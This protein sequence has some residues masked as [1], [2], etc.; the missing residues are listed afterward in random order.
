LVILLA[1]AGAFLLHETRGTTLWFDEWSWAFERRGD[2][3]ASL[4]E[5]HNEHLSLV[6][7]AIYKVLFATAG[8]ENHLP[9]RALVIA[10]HLACTA[11]LFAYVRQRAGNLLGLLAA[12]L[13]LF[14]GPGW[15]NILWPFQVGWLLS[16]AAGIGSLLLLDRRDRVGRVAA[17][18]LLGL[19]L[20]SSGIGL[21]VAAGAL[22]ELLWSRER[23]LV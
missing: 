1:C 8:L 12:A 17:C 11:L 6:P 15:H 20:I 18:G 19:S 14:L 10:G 16:L 5:P 4:L 7:V 9:Y 13:L 23:K 3:L 2:G 22:V 21:V